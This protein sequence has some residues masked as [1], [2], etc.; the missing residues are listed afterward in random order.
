MAADILNGSYAHETTTTYRR[1]DV[2]DDARSH[3]KTKV[4]ARTAREHG[5]GE[6]EQVTDDRIE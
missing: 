6:V 2:A 1:G 3:L 5:P 4:L